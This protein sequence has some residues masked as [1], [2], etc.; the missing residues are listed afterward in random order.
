MD[1]QL[2]RRPVPRRC[3]RRW[4][5]M[6]GDVLIPSDRWTVLPIRLRCWRT[7]AVS[8]KVYRAL[9]APTPGLRRIRRLADHL[10]LAHLTYFAL[11]NVS[12]LPSTSLITVGGAL[13][14]N[15]TRRAFQSRLRT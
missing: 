4:S 15:S 14:M 11:S 3:V 13:A 10:P 7:A 1:A 5:A 12:S 2:G 6:Y 9:K 8:A